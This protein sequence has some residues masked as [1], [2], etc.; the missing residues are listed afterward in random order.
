MLTRRRG[1]LNVRTEPV[2]DESAAIGARGLDG[3]TW[4][5]LA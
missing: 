4:C 3:R 2:P 1:Y 5:D